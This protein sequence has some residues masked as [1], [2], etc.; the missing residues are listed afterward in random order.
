MSW[1][2]RCSKGITFTGADRSDRCRAPAV[3]DSLL[4]AQHKAEAIARVQAHIAHVGVK[5]PV[6]RLAPTHAVVER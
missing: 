5:R 1:P 3:D 6:V 4:C 2:R